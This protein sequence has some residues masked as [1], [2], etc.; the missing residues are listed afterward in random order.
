ML[1]WWSKFATWMGL[2]CAFLSGGM[3]L[4]NALLICY[5]IAMRKYGQPTSWAID[6]TVYLTIWAVYLGIVHVEA[7]D[8]QIRMAIFRENLPGLL[9][10]A[11][12]HVS[13]AVAVIFLAVLIWFSAAQA[14][15]SWETGRATISMFQVPTVYLET[16]VPVGGALTLLQVVIGAILRHKGLRGGHG[17]TG[18]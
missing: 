8:G 6:T 1:N 14:F 17:D 7:E 2:A 11:A 10:G 3:V 4:I 5:E 9:A 15:H 18:T 13:T 12:E 16:A